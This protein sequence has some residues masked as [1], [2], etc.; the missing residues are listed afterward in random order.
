MRYK[1][2]IC[3]LDGTL[4][5]NDKSIS[6]RNLK[7]IE[8]FKSEGGLFTFVT[9]RMP[10]SAKIIYSA[11]RPNAP[12]GCINGGGVFD[13]EREEYLWTN[14]LPREALTLVRYIAENVEGVGIQPNTFKNIYFSSEN[15]AMKKFRDATGAP[16]LIKHYDDVQEP[17]A[18]I[19]FGDAREEVI[20]R[21]QDMLLSHPE[22]YKYDFI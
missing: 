6:E 15:S 1:N 7:A 14:E 18:K 16:N 3:D 2:Y 13:T 10:L 5:R 20:L 17:L 9:G 4:L 11:L 21:I 19:L 22:A 12:I 8:Y